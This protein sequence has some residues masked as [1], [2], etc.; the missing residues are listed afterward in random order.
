MDPHA[1]YSQPLLID[2]PSQVLAMSH[3]KYVSCKLVFFKAQIIVG[4]CIVGL[5]TQE[6]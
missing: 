3:N 1:I 2:E 6:K 4:R 5:P